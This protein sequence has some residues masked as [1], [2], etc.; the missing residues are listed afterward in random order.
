MEILGLAIESDEAPTGL[1]M[2]HGAGLTLVQLQEV[3]A[4]IGLAPGRVSEAAAAFETGGALSE[5]KTFAGAPVSLG[6]VVRLPRAPDDREWQILVGELRETFGGRGEEASLGGGAR[7]WIH[8]DLI[9][10]VEP[11]PVGFRLRFTS[12]KPAAVPMISTAGVGTVLGLALMALFGIERFAAVAFVIP[13]LVTL[14]SLG[15][16]VTNVVGLPRWAGRRE[17]QM[18]DIASRFVAMLASTPN[19]DA[20]GS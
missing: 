16:L 19:E 13:V 4:E 9:A 18:A 7:E 6:R 5:R 2:P 10:F 11:T 17:R 8:R 15:M 20:P 14:L 3:G 12:D 1:D